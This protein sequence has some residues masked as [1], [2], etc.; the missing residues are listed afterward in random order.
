MN[1]I[2]PIEDFIVALACGVSAAVNLGWIATARGWIPRLL[3]AGKH[4]DIRSPLALLIGSVGCFTGSAFPLFGYLLPILQSAD[5]PGATPSV[6]LMYL[7]VVAFILFVGMLLFG[8]VA[9]GSMI[10]LC[11]AIRTWRGMPAGAPWAENITNGA[12]RAITA[13]LRKFEEQFLDIVVKGAGRDHA[14]A[15]RAYRKIDD[16]SASTIFRIVGSALQY[17]SICV[18]VQEKANDL[19]AARSL[20]FNTHGFEIDW[21]IPYLAEDAL[22]GYHPGARQFYGGPKALLRWA[23]STLSK[24][25]R[26]PNTSANNVNAPQ[27]G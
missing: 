20:T 6:Q 23:F 26:S 2:N 11:A 17:P 16:N 4:G 14:G 18:A 25:H 1:I 27:P 15:L 12:A 21:D 3:Q 9:T 19:A 7:A 13:Q 8:I 22:N 24:T 5:K 10:V